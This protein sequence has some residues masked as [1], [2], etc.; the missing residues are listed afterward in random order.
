MAVSG[1]LK[2]GVNGVDLDSVLDYFS[3]SFARYIERECPVKGICALTPSRSPNLCP[4]YKECLSCF[5]QLVESGQLDEAESQFRNIKAKLEVELCE[6][7]HLLGALL[8]S[9]YW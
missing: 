6:R 8:V 7:S 9:L 1:K 2:R 3:T 5:D 4:Q